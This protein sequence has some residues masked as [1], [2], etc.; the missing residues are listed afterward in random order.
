MN[1]DEL[2]EHLREEIKQVKS[3]AAGHVLTNERI[4]KK[5]HE[6]EE[7]LAN[8]SARLNFLDNYIVTADNPETGKVVLLADSGTLR[9]CIDV[10]ISSSKVKK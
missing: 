9:E 7:D 6:V 1:R 10:A 5:L 4:S 8:E 3:F 2:I